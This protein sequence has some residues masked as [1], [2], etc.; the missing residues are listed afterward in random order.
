MHSV[1]AG[2]QGL[3]R[4]P[5]HVDN[6]S[7]GVGAQRA[8]DNGGIVDGGSAGLLSFRSEESWERL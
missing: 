5:C 1:C 7:A 3:P 2:G 6:P 8:G 4:D